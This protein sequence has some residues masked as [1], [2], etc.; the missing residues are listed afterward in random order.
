M[1]TF[2]ISEP[3]VPGDVVSVPD[4]MAIAS[5][6]W[7][8][9]IIE[10]AI[11]ILALLIGLTIR[12]T[13]LEPAVVISRSMLPTLAVNTLVLTDIRGSQHGQ[14]QRGEIIIFN[15]PESWKTDE[16][17]EDTIMK[18]IVGL[19]GETV[20]VDSYGAYIN[21]QKIDEPYIV[22]EGQEH[23]PTQY[24]LGPD[25]YFVMGDNRNN[26]DDSRE[27]GPINDTDIRGRAFL[28]IWPLSHFGR[29]PKPQYG[30]SGQ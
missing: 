20:R 29:L 3:D 11:L 16:M 8:R 14:W 30:N 23:D 26:S 4:A 12:A 21:G 5:S 25:E 24:T 15:V 7:P 17:D 13:V 19:P 27:H 10:G 28:Q 18:R 22:K 2:E 9:R 1:S 6:P